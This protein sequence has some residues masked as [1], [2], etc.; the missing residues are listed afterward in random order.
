MHQLSQRRNAVQAEA[1]GL[2][3]QSKRLQAKILVRQDQLAKLLYRHYTRG[4]R[5]ALQL[6][7]AGRDPTQTTLDYHYLKRLSAAQADL[8]ADLRAKAAEKRRLTAAAQE[9]QAELTAIEG[10]QQQ[11]R[12][13]LLSQQKQKQAVLARL[14]KTIKAQRRE[15]GVL[16]RDERRLTKLI[17]KLNKRSRRRTVATSRATRRD[18]TPDG[19]GSGSAFAALKGHLGLPVRG[20][21]AGRYGNP[22]PGGGPAWKG[23]LILAAE[24]SMVKS[25]AVGEVVYADWLRGF[26]NLMIVDHGDGYLSVYGHNQALLKDVGEGVKAGEAIATVGSSGGSQESGLYF[27]LRYQGQA[28]DPLRWVRLR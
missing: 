13:S 25:V 14:A 24:G 9:K 12:A 7:L 10:K 27:E 26:G 28:F 5:D 19:S 2:K 21:I 1:D 17:A 15:I 16:K 20:R 4:E 8:I 3:T 11:T 18:R 23:L 22:R 6:L